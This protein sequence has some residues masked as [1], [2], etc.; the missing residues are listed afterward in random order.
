MRVENKSIVTNG[1]MSSDIISLSVSLDHFWLGAVQCVW[2]G[3][4][5]GNLFIEH[6]CDPGT[7]GN[8]LQPDFGVTNWTLF[9]GSTVAT[10]GAAGM[11]VINC[12]YMGA[13]WLRLHYTKSSGTGTLNV[14]S[15]FKGY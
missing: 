6:S 1:D 3:T 11:A 7:P 4:P 10:G 8:M 5:T 9:T 15:N 12:N 2:T 13:K 14:I